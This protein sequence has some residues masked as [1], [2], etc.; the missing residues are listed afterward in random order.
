MSHIDSILGL[1]CLAIEHVDRILLEAERYS[2]DENVLRE[3]LK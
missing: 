1:P 2:L 3:A